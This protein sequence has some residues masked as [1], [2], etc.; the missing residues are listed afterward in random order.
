MYLKLDNCKTRGV[1][2]VR[3]AADESVNQVKIRK[4]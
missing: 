4:R 3:E 1:V 2:I